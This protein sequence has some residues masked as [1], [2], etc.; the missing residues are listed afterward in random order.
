MRTDVGMGDDDDLQVKGPRRARREG[1]RGFEGAETDRQKIRS[2]SP[3]GM[4]PRHVASGDSLID[5][6]DGYLSYGE[7]NDMSGSSRQGQ[8]A[9]SQGSG[10]PKS[11]RGAN[12][13]RSV[14]SEKVKMAV[15]DRTP[16]MDWGDYDWRDH[17]SDKGPGSTTHSTWSGAR[18]SHRG[19]VRIQDMIDK[20][21]KNPEPPPR[22]FSSTNPPSWAANASHGSSPVASPIRSPPSSP[23]PLPRLPPWPLRAE[24]EGSLLLPD[25]LATLLLPGGSLMP[26]FLTENCV[27]P[28]KI[29]SSAP[30][31]GGGLVGTGES[32]SGLGGVRRDRVF[33]T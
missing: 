7:E 4:R 25:S 28:P 33:S 18:G 20:M 21:H 5:R 10:I 1:S 2:S 23:P 22:V 17:V 27:P 8:G 11:T 14:T 16:V 26:A 6:Y 29:T 13:T 30:T 19:R 9:T 3:M 24:G 15:K 31:I 12:S 32:G